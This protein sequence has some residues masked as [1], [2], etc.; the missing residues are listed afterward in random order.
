MM[1]RFSGSCFPGLIA[2]DAATGIYRIAQE[3]LHNSAK[4]AGRTH[5]KV[6]LRYSAGVI[7][8]VVADSGI[9]FDTLDRRTGLGLISM[10]ERA[11]LM[12]GSFQIH[13]GLGLGTQLRVDVPGT[14]PAGPSA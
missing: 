12:G 9:G 5:I 11:R 1:A 10:E 8:L 14:L 13:S 4:H 7:Q 6:N 2:L 3:A